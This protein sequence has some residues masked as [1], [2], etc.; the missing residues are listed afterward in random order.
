MT[1]VLNYLDRAAFK[2]AAE[3]PVTEL[4]AIL[5]S[6][7]LAGYKNRYG[8]P[9]CWHYDDQELNFILDGI[10]KAGV[11]FCLFRSTDG[12]NE[13]DLESYDVADAIQKACE[14]EK[15]NEP[16]HWFARPLL[17]LPYCENTVVI[18]HF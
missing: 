2:N 11:R 14:N 1:N 7:V 18:D 13:T 3:N 16:Y 6:M 5:S 17:L 12:K 10:R 9:Q 8:D 15:L 4:A